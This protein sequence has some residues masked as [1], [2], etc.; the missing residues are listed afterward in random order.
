MAH[1]THKGP[2]IY[3]VVALILGVITYVEYYIVEFPL[4]WLG[5][6]WTL[7]WLV[8]LSLAK[9]F[10]VIWFFMHLRDDDKLYTGFFASGMVIAMATFIALMAM[11]LLPRAVAPVMAATQPATQAAA[12]G[13]AKTDGHGVDAAT[14]DRITSDGLSRSAAEQADAPRPKDQS[15]TVTPPAAP[16]EGFAL[17]H[18]GQPAGGAAAETAAAEPAA[19]APAEPAAERE[20]DPTF[21][22][23]AAS[24]AYLQNCSACHQAA[25]TGIPGA[26]PPLAGHAA[27]IYE[28]DGGRTYLI[29][30]VLYGL[31][32]PITVNGQT[33]NGMMPP[34][35]QLNDEQIALI[36]NHVVAGFDG[37]SPPDGFDA[38]RAA[39]VAG[40]RGKGM[41]PPAVHTLRGTLG[42][43]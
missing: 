19:A 18:E 33:Y 22:R 36:L 29:D 13:A 37:Q 6:S 23:E 40:E 39:D 24:R 1:G 14:H 21:D 17:R 34:W 26:F 9:F 43:D 5:P 20:A 12:H 38:Y 2:G 25:G 31:M 7:F 15:L 41:T 27:D 35:P 3:V 30:V 28:A 4:A 42:I 10:M 16:A 32:G 8:T 11:F